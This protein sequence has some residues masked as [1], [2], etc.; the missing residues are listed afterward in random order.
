M[1]LGPGPHPLQCKRMKLPAVLFAAFMI[2]ALGYILG[3]FLMVP[4]GSDQ[5]MVIAL[6]MLL[7][8]V[9]GTVALLIALASI[10]LAKQS[11]TFALVF[12]RTSYPRSCLVLLVSIA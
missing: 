2:G 11:A 4:A 7:T 10:K 1:G 5:G 12:A 9:F 3:L 6:A 8:P